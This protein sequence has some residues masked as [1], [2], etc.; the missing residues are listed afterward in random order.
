MRIDEGHGD[1]PELQKHKN[2]NNLNSF[3]CFNRAILFL[4]PSKHIH[5]NQ[6]IDL[7]IDLLKHDESDPFERP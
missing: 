5:V 7:V 2:I 6:V 3:D 4:E 1:Y